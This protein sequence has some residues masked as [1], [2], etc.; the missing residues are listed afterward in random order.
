MWEPKWEPKWGP[1]VTDIR[2]RRATPGDRPCSSRPVGRL[3]ATPG[4]GSVLVWERCIN[5]GD[6]LA[7][8]A[9]VAAPP[10]GAAISR[11][12]VHRATATPCRRRYPHIFTAPYSDSGFRR[13]RRLPVV[14]LGLAHPCAAS[15]RCRYPAA[16][17]PADRRPL[18]RVIPRMLPHQADRLRFHLRAV[19]GTRHVDSACIPHRAPRWRPPPAVMIGPRR[20]A[21]PVAGQGPAHRHD[22]EPVPERVDETDDHRRS[23]SPSRKNGSPPSRSRWS[24]PARGSYGAAPAAPPTPPWSCWSHKNR[25][26]TAPGTSRPR[27]CADESPSCRP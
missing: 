14:D 26:A 23:G 20:D 22:A 2:P 25:C 17:H 21:D 12:T 24:A 8:A 16:W 5:R 11:S 4:A 19:L 13:S 1:T 3:R 6:H 18:R 10:V 9:H 27:R 15:P 7:R